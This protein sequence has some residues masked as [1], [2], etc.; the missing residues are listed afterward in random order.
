MHDAIAR[1]AAI[2]LGQVLIALFAGFA[3]LV[4][5]T[6]AQPFASLSDYGVIDDPTQSNSL[7]RNLTLLILGLALLLVWHRGN[8]AQLWGAVSPGLVAIFGWF[9]LTALLS[10]SPG[11]ALNRLAL[12]G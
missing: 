7:R 5:W 10:A 6:Q 8:F 2:D 1:P 11:L 3:I 9:A 12:A 4:L